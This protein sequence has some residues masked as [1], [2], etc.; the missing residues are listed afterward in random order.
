MNI[1]INTVPVT[2]PLTLSASAASI[3]VSL[4]RYDLGGN[5]ASVF[6]QLLA[7]DGI[8]VVFEGNM[9]LGPDVV[10]AWGTDDNVLVNAVLNKLGL[11][12]SV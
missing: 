4:S 5:T 7:A 10:A 3:R 12:R 6:Y 1:A 11:V 2:Q 8:A 9:N